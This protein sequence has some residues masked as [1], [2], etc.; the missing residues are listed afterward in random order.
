MGFINI[1]SILCC[2]YGWQPCCQLTLHLFVWL[3]PR[4]LIIILC[5]WFFD[6]VRLTMSLVLSICFSVWSGLMDVLPTRWRPNLDRESLLIYYSVLVSCMA[7]FS[8]FF[9][10]VYTASCVS[11]SLEHL[12]SDL[13]ALTFS[14]MAKTVSLS[15]HIFLLFHLSL[16]YLSWFFWHWAALLTGLHV[17]DFLLYSSTNVRLIRD[18]CSYRWQVIIAI[19][20]VSLYQNAIAHLVIW[21]DLFS[22]NMQSICLFLCIKKQKSFEM[23]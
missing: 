1:T 21:I 6:W 16:I 9:S 8:L 7:C 14:K 15:F 17:L 5:I 11:F 12:S 3:N 10:L 18:F 19:K 2:F 4:G 13:M 22:T 23:I 20:Q